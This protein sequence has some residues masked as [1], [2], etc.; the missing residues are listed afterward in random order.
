VKAEG[1]SDEQAARTTAATDLA[2]AGL[3]EH[4]ALVENNW[5]RVE[6]LGAEPDPIWRDIDREADPDWEFRTAREQP[7]ADLVA[8]YERACA[9]SRE[10]VASVSSL[11]ALSAGTSR[12]TGERFNLRWILL[13]M[14]EETA[15]HNGHVDL[16]REAIDGTT[17]D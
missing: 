17:G 5:F 8:L 1:L 12:R 4:L 13:H 6:L 14:V 10:A 15:R 3:L 16:L 7:V 2:I 9:A 11:D